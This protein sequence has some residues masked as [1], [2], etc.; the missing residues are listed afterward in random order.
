MTRNQRLLDACYRT[1]GIAAIYS[2]DGQP[3]LPILIVAAREDDVSDFGATRIRSETCRFNVRRSQ[4][5][6][7]QK[8]ARIDIGAD[9]YQIKDKPVIIDEDRLEWGIECQPLA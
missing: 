1:H 5:P 2:D 6:A 4:L 3:A 8:G 7:P 9:R